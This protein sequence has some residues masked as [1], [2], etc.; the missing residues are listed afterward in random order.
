MNGWLLS[1]ITD[2]DLGLLG[3]TVQEALIE[4]ATTTHSRLSA[5]KTLLGDAL[6]GLVTVTSLPLSLATIFGRQGPR[7]GALHFWGLSA[8]AHGAAF[9]V[10]AINSRKRD[11]FKTFTGLVASAVRGVLVAE[12]AHESPCVAVG[13][14]SLSISQRR[15]SG[16][17]Y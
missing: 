11:A 15:G 6:K 1:G 7:V 8:L 12:R 14:F 2:Y 5:L 10:L 16:R 4:A 13:G 3:C 17:L 9:D